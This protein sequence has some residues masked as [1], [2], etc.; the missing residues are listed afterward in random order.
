[1]VPERV[2]GSVYGRDRCQRTA[3]RGHAAVA[4]PI[5]RQAQR[6]W[7]RPHGATSR[8]HAGRT[9]DR[10]HRG[11]A[12][13]ATP[14]LASTPVARRATMPRCRTG[15][16]ASS[17]DRRLANTRARSASAGRSFLRRAGGLVPVMNPI[18]LSART[19]GHGYRLA[20]RRHGSPPD[21]R[22]PSYGAIRPRRMAYRVSSTRSRIPSFSSMLARWRSTVLRLITSRSAISSLV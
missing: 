5:G 21:A 16:R 19:A 10:C 7:L 17:R 6:R 20:S 13:T 11:A 14:S 2:K 1:M 8:R 18:V 15:T 4:Y 12:A 22:R 3:F 9:Q